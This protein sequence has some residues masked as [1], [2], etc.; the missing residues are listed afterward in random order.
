M[1]CPSIKN[2]LQE[3]VD[4]GNGGAVANTL[5]GPL[6]LPALSEVLGQCFASPAPHSDTWPLLP[7]LGWC[8]E[9][10]K[11]PLHCSHCSCVARAGV[12]KEASWPKGAGAGRALGPDPRLCV[13][14]PFWHK[15]DPWQRYLVEGWQHKLC[16]TIGKPH[17]N[18]NK[19]K[20]MSIIK[21]FWKQNQSGKRFRSDVQEQC[22]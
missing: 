1:S 7:D 18:N 3:L 5:K 10:C 17:N 2:P 8:R 14:C 12:A 21:G 22:V 6:P 15:A 11:K 19:L 9:S 13:G 16:R 4:V 20:I